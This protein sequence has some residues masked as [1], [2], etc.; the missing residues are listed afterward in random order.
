MRPSRLAASSDFMCVLWGASFVCAKLRQMAERAGRR[1]L[2]FTMAPNV[3]LVEPFKAH[4]S[5]RA[6]L[7]NIEPRWICRSF[8]QG[9]RYRARV[10]TSESQTTHSEAIATLPGYG[11]RPLGDR[12]IPSSF[13]PPH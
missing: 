4:Y 1:A 3:F 5:I 2:Y 6:W 9:G 7:H 8:K 11:G 10:A 13:A 12:E